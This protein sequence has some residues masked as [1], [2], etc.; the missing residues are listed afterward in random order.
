LSLFS[1]LK[2]KPAQ[3][4]QPTEQRKP[5]A[6]LPTYVTKERVILSKAA[7]RL[8]N[9][10]EM[11]LAQSFAASKRL[12]L[13]LAVRPAA[14]MEPP[15]ATW[16]NQQGVEITE[17]Q[18]EDYSVYFGHVKGNGQE[19]DGWVLGNSAALTA[20]TQS[21]RSLWLRDRLR[22]GASFGGDTLQE[23]ENALLKENSR[24]LN[25]DGENVRD[26]VMSLI[27]AAKRDGGT[28]FIQ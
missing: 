16:L 24:V 7:N 21:T 12:K 6:C 14:Q 27:A 23:L 15:L 13:M 25:V 9:T 4:P 26:A 5:R 18:M 17:A 1:F 28:V 10:E 11:R 3:A 2:R 20:L 22:I 19:G 8:R